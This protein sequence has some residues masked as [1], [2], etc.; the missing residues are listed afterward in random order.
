MRA[1]NA[2]L[3]SQVI[4]PESRRNLQIDAR[5]GSG[6][7]RGI[8]LPGGAGNTTVQGVIAGATPPTAAQL[9]AAAAATAA[10]RKMIDDYYAKKY[11]DEIGPIG[12]VDP[13]HNSPPPGETDHSFNDAVITGISA[14]YG[15][16]WTARDAAKTQGDKDKVPEYG[17]NGFKDPYGLYWDHIPT[18]GVSNE[19]WD[20]SN[21]IV[22]RNGVQ[23]AFTVHTHTVPPQYGTNDPAL[24]G[25]AANPHAVPDFIIQPKADRTATIYFQPPNAPAGKP[26]KYGEIIL[27]NGKPMIQTRYQRAD[28]IGNTITGA[29][30]IGDP[31]AESSNDCHWYEPWNV[32]HWYDYLYEA[33][34]P[35]VVPLAVLGVLTHGDGPPDDPDADPGPAPPDRLPL[36]TGGP[37]KPSS[38]AV[39]ADLLRRNKKGSPEKK[40]KDPRKAKAAGGRTMTISSIKP[41]DG[42]RKAP[43]AGAGSTWTIAGPNTEE[44]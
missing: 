1:S 33:L 31:Y 35:V 41:T 32:C 18:P 37:S 17:T 44:T 9:A 28:Q 39:K 38:Q 4:D 34:I 12:N 25:H 24:V 43:A 6:L 22:T 13:Y 11:P 15:A 42:G 36:T 26:R 14:V 23:H 16:Y 20:F 40:V 30:A 21:A 8:S 5:R 7:H 27:K 19:E 2:N 29:A 10:N 3:A